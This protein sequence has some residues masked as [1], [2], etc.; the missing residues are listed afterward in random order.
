MIITHHNICKGV[1]QQLN[2]YLRSQVK[3]A[4]D[5]SGINAVGFIK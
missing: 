4:V 2:G 3:S 5:G 1:S